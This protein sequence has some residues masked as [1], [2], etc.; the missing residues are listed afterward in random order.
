MLLA[1]SDAANGHQVALAPSDARAFP[2]H[3]QVALQAAYFLG[4]MQWAESDRAR[5]ILELL[6]F[7]KVRSAWDLAL[8]SSA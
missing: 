8:V 3:V 7:P 1:W 2:R 5:L 4:N 6:G